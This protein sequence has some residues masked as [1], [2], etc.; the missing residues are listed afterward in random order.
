[1]ELRNKTALEV[2]IGERLYSLECNSDS[3]LGELHDALTQM[4]AYIVD[5]INTQQ[6]AE[7]VKKEPE[8]PKS[9]Q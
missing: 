5:R 9:A 1:M 4:K 3:L 6:D 2:K 7:N 8:C